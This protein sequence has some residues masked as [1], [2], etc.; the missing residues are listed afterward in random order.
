MNFNLIQ[1]YQNYASKILKSFLI[2]NKISILLITN[3][4]EYKI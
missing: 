2:K 3:K 1:N 4:N